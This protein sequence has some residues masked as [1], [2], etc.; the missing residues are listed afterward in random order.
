M[1]HSVTVLVIDDHE[2]FRTALGD[3]VAATEGFHLIG[4][5]A[6]GEE[7]LTAAAALGPRW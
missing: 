1:E 5:A 3:I 4:E 2:P 6:S 7:A